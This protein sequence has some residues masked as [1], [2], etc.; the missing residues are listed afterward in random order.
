LPSYHIDIACFVADVE[1][2]WIDNLFSRVDIA[3]AESPGHGVVRRL[4]LGAIRQITLT[5]QL[6]QE[7]GLSIERAALLAGALIANHGNVRTPSGFA[8][9][10]DLGT[11]DDRV[12]RRLSDAVEAVVLARRGRPPAKGIRQP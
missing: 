6:V 12:E 4:S 10:I 3:G 8:I 1:R 5:R 9:S 2:K 11:F 7:M